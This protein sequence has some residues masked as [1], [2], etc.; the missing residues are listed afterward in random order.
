M[1]YEILCCV[2]SSI[3][4]VIGL[5]LLARRNNPHITKR[6]PWLVHINHWSNLA[7]ILLILPTATSTVTSE[8]TP[9]IKWQLR[10]C[11]ILI[12]HFLIFFSYLLRSYRIHT[13]LDL[14]NP[15]KF[16]RYLVRT[17]Q[18][19]LVK[20]LCLLMFPVFMLSLLILSFDKMAPYFPISHS[21]DSYIQQQ[22]SSCIYI[23]SSFLEQLF[24]VFVVFSLRH[25]DDKYNMARE[26]IIVAGLWYISPLFSNFINIERELWLVSIV[27]RNFLLAAVSSLSPVIASYSKSQFEEPLTLD[28]LNSLHI[29][30]ENL[31]CLKFFEKFLMKTCL[32]SNVLEFYQK[33]ECDM[34]STG[35]DEFWE[36][37]E[38]LKKGRLPVDLHLEEINSKSKAGKAKDEAFK[39][40]EAKF[41]NDFL[42]SEECEEL[43]EVVKKEE[44]IVSRVRRTSLHR[45][46]Y[47]A[48]N[49]IDPKNVDRTS[50]TVGRLL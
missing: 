8:S 42:R 1:Y 7:E 18:K 5:L 29:I 24:F 36:L 17:T 11:G 2:I 4:L 30:L 41:Y 20:I 31:K 50:M 13:I 35:G 34:T 45:K 48:S 16:Q 14:S 33:C 27:G 15:S 10:D 39:Y 40:M 25:V 38:Y 19:F 23:T 26:L 32:G 21:G 28:M 9:T 3:Y 22:I 37:N 49:K 47:L 43:K 44:I 46:I 6:S 12:C